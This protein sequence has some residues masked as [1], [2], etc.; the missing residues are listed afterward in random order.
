MLVWAL[1]AGKP[2]AELCKGIEHVALAVFTLN[3]FQ[4]SLTVAET[5]ARVTNKIS[6]E[7]GLAAA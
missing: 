7:V 4:P 1:T 6:A 3:E 5:Q 2:P